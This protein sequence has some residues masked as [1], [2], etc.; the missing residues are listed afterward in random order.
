[1]MA[2]AANDGRLVTPH[3]TREPDS[4]PHD[5]SSTGLQLVAYETEQ[6]RWPP[7]RIEGLSPDTLWRV[8]AGL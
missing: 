7:P 8:R 1:M 6:S 2:A 5:Q 4:R 3:F